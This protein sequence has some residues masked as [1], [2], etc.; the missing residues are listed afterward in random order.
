MTIEVSSF[1]FFFCELSTHLAITRFPP[2]RAQSNIFLKLKTI[3]ISAL[4]RIEKN[5]FSKFKDED[6]GIG[7]VSYSN[8][9]GGSL[10]LC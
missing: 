9:W 2:V 4:G 3:E 5:L 1:E 6:L 10:L 8:F 7:F